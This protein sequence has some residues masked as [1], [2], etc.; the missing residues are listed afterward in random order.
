MRDYSDAE[1]A[2]CVPSGDPLDKAGGYAIQYRGFTPVARFEGCHASIMGLPLGHLVRALAAM[3]VTVP[4]DVVQACQAVTGTV[5]C[6]PDGGDS[7]SASA[8]IAKTI[9]DSVVYEFNKCK[10]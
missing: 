4:V 6:L 8:A 2:T 10:A 9:G 7:R 1:I 5:C 3:G